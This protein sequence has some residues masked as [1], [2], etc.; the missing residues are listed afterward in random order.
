ME[1]F[2]LQS[3]NLPISMVHANMFAPCHRTYMVCSIACGLEC[4]WLAF[5]HWYETLADYD[6][7]RALIL[8]F[9]PY[10][11]SRLVSC[12]PVFS[13]HTWIRLSFW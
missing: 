10:S 1:R 9:G 4:A 3:T 7:L 12:L 13:K 5:H 11:R 6:S 8:A 2:A